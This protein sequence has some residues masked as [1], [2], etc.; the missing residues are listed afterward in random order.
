MLDSPKQ[1]QL[2]GLGLL[3]VIAFVGIRLSMARPQSVE[4]DI[5][6]LGYSTNAVGIKQARFD[7]QN[8]SSF[9]IQRSIFYEVEVREPIGWKRLPVA[10]T[11]NT[12]KVQPASNE[13]IEVPV[14]S[15]SFPWRLGVTYIKPE[16]KLVALINAIRHKLGFSVHQMP[17]TYGF[18]SEQIAP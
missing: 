17:E 5:R 9:T 2:L 12:P 7:L 10:T 8:N 15:T 13:V 18:V 11:V 6:F 4:V 3:L 16:N 1:K 14:P